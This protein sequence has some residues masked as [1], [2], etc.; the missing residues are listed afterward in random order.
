VW[1]THLLEVPVAASGTLTIAATS[2]GGM[3]WVDAFV[4]QVP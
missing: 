2:V 4:L 1:E 3:P